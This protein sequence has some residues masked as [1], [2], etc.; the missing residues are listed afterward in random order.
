M[1]G[2]LNLLL[3]ITIALTVM[4]VF[5][6]NENNLIENTINKNNGSGKL[7]KPDC[8]RRVTTVWKHHH[9]VPV[10]NKTLGFWPTSFATMNAMRTQYGF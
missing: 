1:N 7:E 9:Y 6:C 10:Q 2:K 3:T 8:S 5:S 4:L